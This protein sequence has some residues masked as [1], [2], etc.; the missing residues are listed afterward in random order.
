[1]FAASPASRSEGFTSLQ[2]RLMALLAW[3]RR[4]SGRWD[5]C[6][7][8]RV[9]PDSPEVIVHQILTYRASALEH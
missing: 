7:Q 1:M 3:N 6:Y 8:Q 9:L 4:K 2:R 5:I